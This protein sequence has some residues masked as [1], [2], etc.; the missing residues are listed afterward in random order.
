MEDLCEKFPP[1][2]EG[3]LNILDGKSKLNLKDSSREM[4]QFVNKD[5]SYWMEILKKSERNLEGNWEKIFQ[6]AS[7]EILKEFV[8]AV[9]QFFKI[10][11]SW[12][13]YQIW[14]SMCIAAKYGNLQ[15]CKF[16][17]RKTGIPNPVG[18]DGSSALHL[19]V[20]FGHLEVTKY[21]INKT[22]NENPKNSF[23]R[24]PL[25]FAAQEG[26]LQICKLIIENVEYKSPRDNLRW[27]TPLHW[28]AEMGHWDICRM[29]I[30]HLSNENP[31]PGK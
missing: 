18:M 20:Q 19:A 23:G 24:T 30:K 3:I 27:D 17:I 16:I 5:R 6:K 8:I 29:F 13:I 15:L 9:G 4:N 1:L 28:A 22:E 26:H 11:F 7:V 2:G 12:K 10:K 21:I 31:N 14:P 25:H